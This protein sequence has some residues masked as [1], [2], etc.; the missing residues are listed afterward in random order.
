MS[1]CLKS[2]MLLAALPLCVAAMSQEATATDRFD[3][4]VEVVSFRSLVNT[5]PGGYV[6]VHNANIHVDIE[7]SGRKTVNAPRIIANPFRTT[8]VNAQTQFTNIKKPRHKQRQ[9][10]VSANLTGFY[11]TSGGKKTQNLG[12]AKG[13]TSIDLFREADHSKDDKAVQTVMV[14]SQNYQMIVRVTVIER[15]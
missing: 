7:G 11:T 1:F 15:D 5:T 6:V 14:K 4:K 3:V 10:K 2:M 13:E 9:I 12:L 8:Q